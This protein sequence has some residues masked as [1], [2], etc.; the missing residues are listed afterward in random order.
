MKF[1]II[2]ENYW[3]VDPDNDNESSKS[4]E[5]I[6]VFASIELAKEAIQKACKSNVWDN[7]LKSDYDVYEIDTDKNSTDL[8]GG[9]SITEIRIFN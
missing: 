9:F 5:I 3:T 8:F 7:P 6:G 2:Q 1:Y 4:K